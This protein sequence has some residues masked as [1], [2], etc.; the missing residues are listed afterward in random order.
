MAE[1]W[2][3]TET[4]FYCPVYSEL[5]EKLGTKLRAYVHPDL[6]LGDET[7]L[8]QHSG[9]TNR[10]RALVWEALRE[11]YHSFDADAAEG[12]LFENLGKLTGIGLEPA[13]HSLVRVSL[14]FSATDTIEPD[15]TFIAH[16]DREDIRFTPVETAEFATGSHDVL[17]RAEN[18]GPVEAG[19]GK[20]TVISAG[21]AGL[22]SATNANDAVPGTNAETIEEM[23]VRRDESIA[24]TGGSTDSAILADVSALDFILSTRV[25]SNYGPIAD[26]NG[27]PPHSFEV[28]VWTGG[29]PT[30]EQKNTIAQTIHD[31][32]PDGIQTYGTISGVAAD[33][34]GDPIVVWFTAAEEKEIWLV[35]ELTKE[36]GAAADSETKT[37]WAA[38]MNTAHEP[39][40]DVVALSVRAWPLTRDKI[41]DV[42]VFTLGFAAAPVGTSNLTI[43]VRQIAR[44]D[45]TRITITT[46]P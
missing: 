27:L 30:T 45:S 13:H 15:V 11:T 44:F 12:V 6:D 32:G 20:L 2:G 28:I 37:A 33:A 36:A 26:A 14:T 24:I 18:T 21:P 41:T 22:V 38:A 19:A 3:V 10:S 23:R 4:G 31:T 29:T 25:L 40:A 1:P 16:E 34:A 42:P 39:A 5:Q 9:I 17:F 35:A 46:T 43:G 8:G 7:I